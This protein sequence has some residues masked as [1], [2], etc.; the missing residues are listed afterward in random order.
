M[1]NGPVAYPRFV[2]V[3]TSFDDAKDAGGNRVVV[4][5]RDAIRLDDAPR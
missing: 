4:G 3:E 1:A 2:V 5:G